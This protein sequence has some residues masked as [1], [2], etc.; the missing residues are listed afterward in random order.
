MDILVELE[1]ILS[2]YAEVTLLGHTFNILPIE[3]G[4]VLGIITFVISCFLMSQ[5]IISPMSGGW[6][7]GAFHTIVTG[8]IIEEIVF[9][10]ALITLLIPF[11]NSTIIAIAASALLFGIAHIPYGGLKLADGLI[12]GIIMGFAFMQF[13]IVVPIFA[14]ITHNLLSEIG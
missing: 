2:K 12:F 5:I 6:R 9:R 14:H 1:Q 4:A 7:T 3:L 11:F 10:F 8:P 13:G